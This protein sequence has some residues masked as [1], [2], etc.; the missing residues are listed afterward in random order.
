MDQGRHNNALHWASHRV[1]LECSAALISREAT[2]ADKMLQH[3]QLPMTLH[4][5]Q[6]GDAIHAEKT[7]RDQALTVAKSTA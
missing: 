3:R 5:I 6:S 7:I 2:A 4:P 1:L